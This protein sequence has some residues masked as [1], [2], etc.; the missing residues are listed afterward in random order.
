MTAVA[1]RTAGRTRPGCRSRSSWRSEAWSRSC[2]SPPRVVPLIVMPM[3]FVIAFSGSFSSPGRPA[4]VPHRQR[5]QLVRALRHPPGRRLRR[6]RH[7]LQHGARHRDR[8][9]RP[10]APR[11]RVPGRAVRRARRWPASCAPSFTTV[12]VL[13]LGVILGAELPGGLLGLLA[14]WVAALGM[15]VIA[16]GWALGVVYRIPDQRAGPILQIGIFFTMFLSTGNVPV[17]DQIGWTQTIARGQPAHPDARAGPPGL[18]RRGRLG[19]H[20]ARPRRHRRR[21][22][23]CSGPSPSP[24][25]STAPRST[26]RTLVWSSRT[27]RR[28]LLGNRGV[29]RCRSPS[30]STGPSTRAMSSPDGC[31]STTCATTWGSPAPT[32]GATRRAAAPAPCSSTASR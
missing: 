10:P 8:V 3:F 13:V 7:R 2:G 32:S 29:R 12:V 30:R 15:A 25:S 17:E 14:L 5:L 4:V 6:L 19:H 16:T 20:L 27:G 18:P 28:G 23:S 9:L 24:A 1:A 21:R 22:R 11:A 26:T 31:S